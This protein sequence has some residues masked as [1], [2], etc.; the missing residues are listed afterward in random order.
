[1]SRLPEATHLLCSTHGFWAN[2]ETRNNLGLDDR[3]FAP[4]STTGSEPLGTLHPSLRCGLVLAGANEDPGGLLTGEMIAGM[5]LPRL[6]TVVLSACDSALGEVRINEGS[7]NLQRAFHLAGARSVMASLWKADDEYAAHFVSLL[8]HNLWSGQKPP[9][10]AAR[11]A[12]LELLDRLKKEGGIA[13]HPYYWAGWSLS[14]YP[15]EPSQLARLQPIAEEP[16]TVTADASN[17]ASEPGAPASLPSP[18]WLAIPALG[19]VALACFFGRKL[20]RSRAGKRP[21]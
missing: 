20:S 7:F 2:T 6:Q 19:L 4:R 8:H 13:S 21:L 3:F 14:G 1:M 15:G 11:L 5:L 17:E 16:D 18:L 12:Q 9:L 10:E